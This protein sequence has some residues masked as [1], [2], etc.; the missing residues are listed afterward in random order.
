MFDSTRN[1]VDW[2]REAC[3]LAAVFLVGIGI[4][5]RVTTL[6]WDAGALLHADERYL[7]MLLTALEWPTSVAQYLNS[8][9]S[10]LN[11]LNLRDVS[12]YV[13]G[14]LPLFVAKL[15]IDVTGVASLADAAFYARVLVAVTD[16]IAIVIVFLLGRDT[17]S[18]R[19]GL[20]A[21]VFYALAVLPL[22][23]SH[24]FTVDPFLNLFLLLSLL[25]AVRLA[26]K[27]RTGD[28]WLLGLFWGCALASKLS[29]LPFLPVLVAAALLGARGREGRAVFVTRCL[30]P[31]WHFACSS[32]TPS[33]GCSHSIRVSSTS[34][35]NFDHCRDWMR[36]C[37][38]QSS[39]RAV[40]ACCSLWRTW[41]CGVWDRSCF[42]PDLPA[43]HLQAFPPGA[44]RRQARCYCYCGWWHCS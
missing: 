37:H 20:L 29:A 14:T 13:Y 36:R 22:Q 38:P 43:P 11:P 30:R 25:L 1:A 34:C 7:V 8:A 15:W 35:S 9:E 24:F 3:L 21:A 44:G 23:L 5:L 16:C 18:Y 4:V 26:G 6:S 41:R 32:P 31:H 2:Q 27:G 40:A 39:G 17:F 28:A 12:A 42:W 19:T 33:P 10:P